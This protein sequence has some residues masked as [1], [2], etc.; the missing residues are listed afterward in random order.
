MFS[1]LD[2]SLSSWDAPSDLMP[3]QSNGASFW[4]RAG[5][6]SSSAYPVSFEAPNPS[7]WYRMIFLWRWIQ[8][9][10]AVAVRRTV[11]APTCNRQL[12]DPLGMAKDPQ[13]ASASGRTYRLDS[14]SSRSA[15]VLSERDFGAEHDPQIARYGPLHPGFLIYP[16]LIGY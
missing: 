12:C 3:R 13:S 5:V 11:L 8:Y 16:V 7:C 4:V 1:L 2:Y 15:T 14:I 9:L 10:S 6:L